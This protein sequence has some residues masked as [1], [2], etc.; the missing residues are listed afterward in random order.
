MLAQMKNLVQ[1]TIA[2][3]TNNIASPVVSLTRISS[4]TTS[5]MSTTNAFSYRM[6][7]MGMFN[8]LVSSQPTSQ[9]WNVGVGSTQYPYQALSLGEGHEIPPSYPFAE[10]G[11][12]PFFV[13]NPAWVG[14]ASMGSRSKSVSVPSISAQFTL[15]SG[16][17]NNPFIVSIVSVWGNPF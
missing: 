15:Y 17:K 12:I 9:L 3:T 14:A 2:T 1:Y 7:S 5:F 6:S 4:A 8:A 11:S 10:S 13:P 16:F